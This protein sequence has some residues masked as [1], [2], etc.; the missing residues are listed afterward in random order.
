M[1]TFRWFHTE[2]L[3]ERQESE[4]APVSTYERV[5]TRPWGALPQHQDAPEYLTMG[6]VADLDTEYPVPGQP[7]GTWSLGT[8][9]AA[10]E[11][12]EAEL[13]AALQVPV[14]ESWGSACRCSAC[15]AAA[16]HCHADMDSGCTAG[17]APDPVTH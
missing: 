13:Q 7:A 12:E 10:D 9:A 5:P 8:D 11:L 3:P 16:Y 17:L 1:L 15:Y 14:H 4:A 6:G 2:M